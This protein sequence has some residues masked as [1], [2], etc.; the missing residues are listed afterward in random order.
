MEHIRSKVIYLSQMSKMIHLGVK[1][2][3]SRSLLL[4]I[5]AWVRN[6]VAITPHIPQLAAV[7]PPRSALLTMH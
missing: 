1:C 4:V 3:D 6:I 2:G 7:C 5:P